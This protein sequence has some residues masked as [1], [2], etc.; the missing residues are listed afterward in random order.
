M[1]C[2]RCQVIDFIFYQILTCKEAKAGLVTDVAAGYLIALEAGGYVVDEN[3]MPLDSNLSYDKKISF[4]AAAN[5]ETL[6]DVMKKLG[7]PP[8]I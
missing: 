1:L 6:A 4:I 2:L 7:L 3:G 5:K 8:K